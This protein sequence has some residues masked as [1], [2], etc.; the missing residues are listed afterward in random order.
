MLNKIR[1]L[2]CRH[3]Y[4]RIKSDQSGFISSGLEFEIRLYKCRCGHT[5][6]INLFVK[7]HWNEKERLQRDTMDL[8][9][10]GITIR[11]SINKSN[12]WKGINDIVKPKETR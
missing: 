7:D 10:Y 6:Q 9:D 1:Q 2:L 3:K 12:N 5:K 4:D 8:H 11:D